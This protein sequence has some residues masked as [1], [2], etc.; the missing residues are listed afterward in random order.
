MTKREREVARCR[1]RV[2]LLYH[3]LFALGGLGTRKAAFGAR[4]LKTPAGSANS[5]TG[6]WGN[7]KEEKR[8]DP[9]NTLDSEP[10]VSTLILCGKRAAPFHDSALDS[11]LGLNEQGS[12]SPDTM[13]TPGPNSLRKDRLPRKSGAGS[14]FYLKHSL[15]VT[16]RPPHYGNQDIMRKEKPPRV[17]THA[18]TL[19]PRAQVSQCVFHGLSIHTSIDRHSEHTCNS[20]LEEQCGSHEGSEDYPVLPLRF[21][22]AF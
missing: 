10:W 13:W 15:C 8:K 17:H 14:S 20:H 11:A 22:L 16:N 19:P 6:S 18:H 21:L 3:F 1:C 9:A 7:Q 2:I 5:T 4:V 12:L